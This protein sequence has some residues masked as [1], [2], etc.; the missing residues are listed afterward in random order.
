[1][2]A[3]TVVRCTGVRCIFVSGELSGCTHSSFS[4][5][6]ERRLKWPPPTPLRS[7]G[8]PLHHRSYRREADVRGSSASTRRTSHD[9]GP[10]HSTVLPWIRLCPSQGNSCTVQFPKTAVSGH[11]ECF[12]YRL[13]GCSG[14]ETDISVLLT[15]YTSVTVATADIGVP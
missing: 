9:D 3:Y 2:S 15:E 5:E 13:R 11:H 7:Q 10:T 4:T 8:G 12:Y 14:F 6:A 1:M